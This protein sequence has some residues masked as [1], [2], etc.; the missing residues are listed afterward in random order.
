MSNFRQAAAIAGVLVLGASGPLG[1][2]RT[3]QP[4]AKS[5]FGQLCAVCH[6]QTGAGDGPAASALKPRPASFADSSF[7]AARTDQQ[8]TAVITGGKPPMPAFGQQLSPAQ[9]KSLVAYVRQL[10]RQTK[11]TKP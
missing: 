1:S 10:G 5:L 3:Q 8:L 9:V 2:P 7:Q 4:D 11:K 6:G